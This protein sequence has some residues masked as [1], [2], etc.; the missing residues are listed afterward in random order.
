[1]TA[2][3][4]V[5]NKTAVAVA[6][7]SAVTIGQNQKILNTAN[8][9]FTLSKYHPVGIVIYNSAAFVSIP[10]EVL[11]KEYRRQRGTVPQDKLE[12][13][14]IDFVH[15][16]KESVGLISEPAQKE[17]VCAAASKLFRL[18]NQEVRAQIGTK[19]KELPL[20]ERT[21]EKVDALAG[22]L[23]PQAVTAKAVQYDG[24]NAAALEDQELQDY[25]LADFL[26]FYGEHLARTWQQELGSFP[27]SDPVREEA[28]GLLHRYFKTQNFELSSS[29]WSGIGIIGY[30]DKEIYP[31]CHMLHI[32]EVIGGRV[33]VKKEESESCQIND[34]ES[35]AILPFAQRDVMEGFLSGVRPN[36]AA[37]YDNTFSQ[38]LGGVNIELA[39]FMKT[40]AAQLPSGTQLPPLQLNVQQ[41][42]GN[43]AQSINSVQN[44][45]I[46]QPM[47][48]SVQGLSKDD[49]AEMAESLIHLTYLHRRINSEPESVGGP[50][51][52]AVISKGDGFIWIKR[53]FYFRPELN[54]G[55]VQNYFTS[56]LE[57]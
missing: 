46:I 22:V 44:E 40:L 13:Y 26:A 10:W 57:E 17:V 29:V 34:V 50:I 24:N 28:F 33:R 25:S 54:P 55:F 14:A 53:K 31:G 42:V 5:L 20:E 11:I 9:L 6:A 27:A 16:V 3:I 47:L 2:V 48:E 38:L 37:V 7:D 43:F 15:Y 18:L 32:A 19:L 8:K 30:G 52:V 51:D 35:S 1:M 36:L 23:L 4:G 12:G 49:L 41:L 45:K 56:H 39:S 21:S